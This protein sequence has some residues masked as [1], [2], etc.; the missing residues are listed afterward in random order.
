M[1]LTTPPAQWQVML[2]NSDCHCS[3]G[4]SQVKG[5]LLKTAYIITLISSGGGWGYR[6]SAKVYFAVIDLSAELLMLQILLWMSKHIS[7]IVH[8]CLALYGM[9]NS[10]PTCVPVGLTPPSC[11][12]W[13]VSLLMSSGF[14]CTDWFSPRG[15]VLLWMPLWRSC[16][17]RSEA[18]WLMYTLDDSDVLEIIPIDG[19]HMENADI[20]LWCWFKKQESGTS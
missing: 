10:S 13:P 9:L 1:D 3:K 11:F 6:K 8:H 7:G 20:E 17:I 2:S 19:T 16:C 12:C 5:L 14:V 4:G 18:V 15:T